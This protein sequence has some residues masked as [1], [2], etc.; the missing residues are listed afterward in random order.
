MFLDASGCKI[1]KFLNLNSGLFES[2]FGKKE[3]EIKTFFKRVFDKHDLFSLFQNFFKIQ[4]GNP[5]FTDVSFHLR[6]SC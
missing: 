6:I 1:A 2:S 5:P 3:N 4:L